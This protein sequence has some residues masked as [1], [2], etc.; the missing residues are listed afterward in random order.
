VTPICDQLLPIVPKQKD[1]EASVEMS[2]IIFEPSPQ[3]I[4]NSIIPKIVRVRLLQACLDAKASEHGSRM[5]AMDSA[6]KNGDELVLKLQLLHNKLRQGNITTELL[7]IIGGAN[8]L[9]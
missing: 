4:F 2:D 9:E 8:A 6:T 1:E 5:T 7:D 3:A